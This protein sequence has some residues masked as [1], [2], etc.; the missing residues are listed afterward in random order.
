MQHIFLLCKWV[1]IFCNLRY[2]GVRDMDTC[3]K[4]HHSHWLQCL[5]HSPAPLIPL[6]PHLVCFT[7]FRILLLHIYIAVSYVCNVSWLITHDDISMWCHALYT[8]EN[9][10]AISCS[11]GSWRCCS[12]LTCHEQ[13]SLK[14]RYGPGMNF[15]FWNIV[16][17]LDLSRQSSC[18]SVL[19]RTK[20]HPPFCQN[21][22]HMLT[23]HFFGILR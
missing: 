9:C 7:I 23:G 1:G 14:D 16:S 18:F 10:A 12:D 13:A 17:V 20:A 15:M 19:D 22:P 21:Y 6:A 3:D 8:P 2:H 4:A 5:P 11:K